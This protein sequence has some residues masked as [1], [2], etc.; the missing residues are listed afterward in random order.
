MARCSKPSRSGPWC[1]LTGPHMLFCRM[2]FN[3]LDCASAH[4][5]RATKRTAEYP[6]PRAAGRGRRPSLSRSRH[7]CA[8]PGGPTRAPGR[9]RSCGFGGP[10]PHAAGILSRVG[11]VRGERRPPLQQRGRF[12][13][14]S[15]AR[16][17]APASAF[18][19]W[20]GRRSVHRRKAV[21]ESARARHCC[22]GG[23]RSASSG[24]APLIF[25]SPTLAR[26]MPHVAA[27]GPSGHARRGA[28]GRL[29]GVGC[30]P[31]TRATR[32][33]RA[34]AVT[35]TSLDEGVLAPA[36]SARTVAVL[37]HLRKV[38]VALP[39]FDLLL[40]LGSGGNRRRFRL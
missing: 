36:L 3:Q 40:C 39:F 2:R 19:R 26:I 32:R 18:E 11:M 15:R 30:L 9:R 28:G 16:A 17:R 14:R 6:V 34:V 27:P 25:R 21:A 29:A 8:G 24:A 7:R 5:A 35:A 20:M 1:S 12:R 23:G 31:R 13:R 10:C 4:A 22:F 33:R 37:G 38:L